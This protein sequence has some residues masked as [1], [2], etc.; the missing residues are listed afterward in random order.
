MT[1]DSFISSNYAVMRH[2]IQSGS[3]LTPMSEEHCRRSIQ[4]LVEIIGFGKKI[5]IFH[6]PLSRARATAEIAKNEFVELKTGVEIIESR[7]WLD[8]DRGLFDNYILQT[9]GLDDETTFTL[10]VAHQPNIENYLD[11]R[12][13]VGNCEIFAKDFVIR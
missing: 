4:K 11:Y 5:R 7:S 2:G 6:S 3:G 8:Y 12:F 10:I 9:L 13:N 1:N